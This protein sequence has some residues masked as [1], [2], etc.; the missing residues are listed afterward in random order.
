MK[1]K[2]RWNGLIKAKSS[3][4]TAQ[5]ANSPSSVYYEPGGY[6]TQHNMQFLVVV[7]CLIAA[8]SAGWLGSFHDHHVP[9]IGPHGVPVDTPEVQHARA[10][11]LAAH[12]EESAKHGSHS[13]DEISSYDDGSYHHNSGGDFGGLGSYGDDYGSS[14]GDYTNH[15]SHDVPQHFGGHFQ[16]QSHHELPVISHDGKPLDTPEVEAAKAHHFAAVHEALSRVSHHGSS[17]GHYRKRRSI[18][19]YGHGAT[20]GHDGHPVETP[21]VQHAKALH[22]AAHAKAGYGGHDDGSHY[23]HHIS[24]VYSPHHG[25]YDHHE[26]PAIGHDGKPLDTAEVEHAKAAHFHAFH[27]AAA[28]NS[29]APHH[30]HYGGGVSIGHNGV[31]ED[32]HE[33]QIA[34]AK[35]FAAVAAAK[36]HHY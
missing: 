31:P 26:I 24:H 21:E 16:F 35:H 30:S 2:I 5:S 8:S 12:A 7:S 6:T 11:H 3:S 15:I 1:E 14:H 10:A 4:T 32:T 20:I 34:K 19:S 23:E 36:G 13:H 17:S 18:Y 22:L 33:V 28:R 29:I 9:V 25:H 27:E